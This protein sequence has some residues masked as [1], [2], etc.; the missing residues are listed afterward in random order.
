MSPDPLGSWR[1][2]I[3]ILYG[4]SFLLPA[5]P[6]YL[7]GLRMF[8]S[9]FLFG[10]VFLCPLAI[11]LWSANPLLWW[12]LSASHEGKRGKAATLGIG[13]ASASSL[14][15]WCFGEFYEQSTRNSLLGEGPG[16]IC[17]TGHFAWI[18]SLWSMAL[19]EVV[20][21]SASRGGRPI[22]FSL[23][24]LMLSVG[25]IA[26]ILGTWRWI[27]AIL[28]WSLLSNLKLPMPG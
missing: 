5:G 18:A 23:K 3:L 4:L 9:S 12:A 20:A 19:V 25:S 6:D 10:L 27:V 17:V 28:S 26:L 16:L 14:S 7:P 15:I 21:W 2:P 11:L 13:S 8:V 1:K 24:G 22:Q